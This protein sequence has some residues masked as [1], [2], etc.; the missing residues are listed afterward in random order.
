VNYFQLLGLSLCGVFCLSIAVG[1][2]RHRIGTSA[3]IAWLTLWTAAGIAIARPQVTVTVARALGI[4]RGADLVFY[5]AILAM[6]AG[7]FAVYVKFRRLEAGITSLVRE[8]ALREAEDGGG[9]RDSGV[10]HK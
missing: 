8:I 5:L 4:A 9:G 2:A 6:F 7:F 3:G 1:L 10:E